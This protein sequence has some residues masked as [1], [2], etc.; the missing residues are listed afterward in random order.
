MCE[1][2]VNFLENLMVT[3]GNQKR[4]ILENQPNKDA[5]PDDN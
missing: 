5:G 3:F 1:F 2:T 4:A